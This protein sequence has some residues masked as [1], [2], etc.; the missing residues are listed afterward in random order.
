MDGGNQ[1]EHIEKREFRKTGR[2]INDHKGAEKTLMNGSKTYTFVSY[3][4]L[5]KMI[6]RMFQ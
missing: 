5:R 6:V 4:V 2:E 3:E 1:K